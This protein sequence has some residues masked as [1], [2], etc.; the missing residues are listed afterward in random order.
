MPDKQTLDLGKLAIER[1][2]RAFHSVAQLA[3][4]DRQSYAIGMMVA[5]AMLGIAHEIM[6]DGME[7]QNGNRPDDESVLHQVIGDLLDGLG[8][9]WAEQEISRSARK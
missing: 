7:A 9:A 2:M 1:C 5:A 6:Q 3:E 8:V 4:N